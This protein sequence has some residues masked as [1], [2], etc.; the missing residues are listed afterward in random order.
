MLFGLLKKSIKPKYLYLGILFKKKARQ[1]WSSACKKC[2]WRKKIWQNF[3]FQFLVWK[4]F[5]SMQPKAKLR[6]KTIFFF[7]VFSF[8]KHSE[9]TSLVM[10]VWVYNHGKKTEYMNGNW[11][12]NWKNPGIPP[13]IRGI[14]T[15]PFRKTTELKQLTPESK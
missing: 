12:N 10:P 1:F 2:T 8:S 5:F 6:F 11:K 13:F 9:K 15:A 3:F 14:P 4:F 7:N